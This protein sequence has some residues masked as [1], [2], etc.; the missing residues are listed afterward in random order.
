MPRKI[1]QSMRLFQLSPTSTVQTAAWRIDDLRELRHGTRTPGGFSDLSFTL[2]VTETE[3]W[4]WRTER[5]LFRLLLEESGGQAIWEGRLEDVELI[6]KWQV[7]LRWYGYWSNFTDAFVNASFNTTGD[8]IIQALRDEI[9]DDAAAALQISTSNAE[10]DTGPNIDQDYVDV[11]MWEAISDPTRGVLRFGSPNDKPMNLTIYE[12]RVIR[13]KERNPSAVDWQAFIKPENGG[14]VPNL[15]ANISWKNTANVVMTV[16]DGPTRTAVAEDSASISKF[17]R[18]DLR[19]TGLITADATTAQ[20]LRDTE[21]AARKDIQQQT[22]GLTLSR[23]WDTN[24]V[25]WPLCRVRAGEVIRINDFVPVTGDLDAVT[26]DAFRT[27]VIEETVCDHDR[28][29]L[30]IRPDRAAGTLSDILLRNGV[31]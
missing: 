25:E 9:D 6:A 21:L 17:I 2:A 1:A 8:A 5:L 13:Y 15:K 18:R 12:D 26:L 10:M 19:L 11:P 20:Q 27:F 28:G 4:Q 30:T 14:G 31:T 24:G 22:N 7:R 29:R 23:V 16:Y 3:Y